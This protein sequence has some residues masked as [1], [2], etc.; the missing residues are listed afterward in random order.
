MAS[1]AQSPVQPWQ[2]SAA[3]TR[4]HA[5]VAPW[6]LWL[7][8]LSVT[9]AMIGGHWDISWHRSIGRDTF[10]TPAHVAIYLCGVLSGISCGYLIL[11]TTFG[12]SPSA[13]A[14]RAA[15]VNIW[16]F[17]GPLGAFI[18]AWGGFA[19][20]ASAP[21]DD[22]WHNAYGLDVKILSPPHV[23]LS[24]GIVTV[25]I[26]ALILILGRMN[27]S[28]DDARRKLERLFLY[29]AGMI[30]VAMLVV[31]LEYQGRV[32]QHSAMFY[33][34]ISM[35]IPLAI[36]MAS[37]ATGNR[38]AATVS[39][40]VYTVLLLGLLWILPL[41]PAEPK[42]G[43][44]YYQV[45]HFVPSGF[46]ILILVPAIVL[47]WL[48]A[49]TTGWGAWR[50]ALVSGVV[51]LGVLLAVQ[52]PFATFLQSPGARNWF[53]GSMY[54]DYMTPPTSYQRRYAFFSLE[55]TAA[56]FWKQ[57]AIALVSAILSTRL[58]LAAGNWMRKVQR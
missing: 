22:W 52:W 42:L 4:E 44:V 36:A 13:L 41:F 14:L 48:W 7:A 34:V 46:P 9:S 6:Y 11:S 25:E 33:R 21:F 32:L 29:V 39:T 28:A 15:S 57:M 8:V 56:A 55:P 23:V 53:F 1:A 5:A 31:S 12:K 18:A 19:M 35:L 24:L 30:V 27:R 40:G 3:V 20:L 58:G 47:D 10:L 2:S 43:P 17:R 26:G 54:F 49:R 38:W 50:Q 37:K 45:T 16:G 51:F